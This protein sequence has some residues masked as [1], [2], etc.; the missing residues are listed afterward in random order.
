MR[1]VICNTSPLQYLHQSGHLQLLPTLYEQIVVPQAVVLEL[2][3]GREL[4]VDLPD[5]S[6]LP[7][8][9]TRQV[10]EPRL[11]PL[12]TDLGQGEREVLGLGAEMPGALLIL[13]D[14]LARQHAALLELA[15]TG[16]LGV[17]LK[18]KQEGYLKALTPVLTQLDALRFRLSPE[19]REE[20]L[21]LAGENA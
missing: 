14:R 18:A 2:A 16:T 11:L 15:F 1:N 19:T 4:G 9:I 21:K 12:A 17:L 6:G 7:W 10:R 8:A 20:V 3:A 5:P 13:D